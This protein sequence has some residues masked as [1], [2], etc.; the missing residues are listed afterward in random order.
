MSQKKAKQTYAK[1]TKEQRQK[2][3]SKSCKKVAA[4]KE[5]KK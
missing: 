4:K 1:I 2:T 3:C 5:H